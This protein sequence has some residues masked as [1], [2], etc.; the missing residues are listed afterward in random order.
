MKVNEELSRIRA[1]IMNCTACPL[2]VGRKNPVP[3]EGP[4]DAPLLLVG[5]APGREEDETGRPFV[6][7]A[8]RLLTEMLKEAGVPRSSVYITSVIKCRPPGN[9]NPKK[10][11]IEACRG[12]LLE[13]IAAVRPEVVV[14]M[15]NVALNSLKEVWK[16]PGGNIG[17]ISGELYDRGDFKV[18][19]TYHPAGVLRDRR[20][21]RPLFVSHIRLAV[22]EA[23]KKRGEGWLG[24]RLEKFEG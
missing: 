3:G 10:G 11:E 20:R 8:G 14:L 24:L 15:G 23:V 18:L 2:H 21:K 17:E 9:R 7:M 13:Q 4:A 22:K 5:E 19:V 16:L 12:Y 1:R 6:G